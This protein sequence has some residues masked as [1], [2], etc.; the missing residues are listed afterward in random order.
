MSEH[1]ESI[2]DLDKPILWWHTIWKENVGFF[3]FYKYTFVQI[4]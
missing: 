2:L 4:D 3:V 1:I